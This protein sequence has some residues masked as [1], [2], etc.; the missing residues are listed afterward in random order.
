MIEHQ[1]AVVRKNCEIAPGI[2][3]L[4]LECPEVFSRIMPGQFIH[5]RVNS[6]LDPLLRRPFSIS[7][8]TAEKNAVVLYKVVGKGTRL[9]TEKCAGEKVDLLGPL[10]NGFDLEAASDADSIV[11]VAGGMG[12]APLT[13]LAETIAGKR[14]FSQNMNVLAGAPNTA[15]LTIAAGLRK[16]GKEISLA[17]DDG[18]AGHHGYVTDLYEKFLNEN[19]G[20][21][22]FVYA[23]GPVPM[24]KKVSLMSPDNVSGQVSLDEMMGC[25]IGACLGC[26]IKTRE[27]DKLVYKR[28]CKDGP[29]FGLRGIHWEE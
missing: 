8:L 20:K 13:L 2:F 26:V 3:H 16:I 27:A 15:E 21:K 25:G 28:V 9:L 1:D 12:A 11:L 22:I 6:S 5:V 4:E 19:S 14:W 17:T 7:S 18:S 23:C 29:V 10:G 24:L